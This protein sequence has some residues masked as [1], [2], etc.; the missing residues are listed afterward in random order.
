MIGVAPFIAGEHF[1]ADLFIVTDAFA[2]GIAAPT[3]GTGNI[4]GKLLRTTDGNLEESHCLLVFI[5]ATD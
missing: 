4:C 3:D 2:H 5:P 1:H